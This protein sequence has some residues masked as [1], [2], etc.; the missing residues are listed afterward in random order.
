MVEALGFKVVNVSGAQTAAHVL[1]LPDAGL[2]TMSELVENVRR[3]ATVVNI[4]VI[5]DCDTGFG[6][7]INV[8]RTIREIIGTGAAGLFF[9]DQVAPKRCGFV[10]GKEIIPL[11]E[12][13]LKY[14]AAADVRDALDPDFVIIA[15]TDARGAVGGGIEE[16]IRRGK[17]YREAGADMIYVEALQ[18]EEEIRTVAR[19]VGQPFTCTFHGPAPSL[20]QLQAWGVSMTGGAMVPTVGLMAVWDLL[21]RMRRE[22]LGPY[23]EMIEQTKNHPLGGFGF[24]D[25]TGFP[26]VQELEQR[27]LPRS[28]DNKLEE[29]LGVYDPRAGG[30]GFAGKRDF[31]L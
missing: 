8:R 29:S 4:P 18:S 3:I 11:E 20:E 1:G 2:I 21:S 7:A 13:V 30:E 19:A 23:N 27:F 15:R 10:R 28:G 5:A 14:R 12:A 25:L 9:E 6:N 26:R 24:F 17:A 31:S 22:G 16:A